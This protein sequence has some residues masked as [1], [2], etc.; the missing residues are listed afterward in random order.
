MFKDKLKELREKE[1]LSQQELADKLFVSRS[2]VAKWENGNGIPSDVNLDAICK[3][4]NVEEEWLLDRKELK[5]IIR[6]NKF[7]KMKLIK[8]LMS[9]LMMMLILIN[10]NKYDYFSTRHPFASV[11]SSFTLLYL[12]YNLF[13]QKGKIFKIINIILVSLCYILNIV[14]WVQTSIEAD[15]HFF[16]IILRR[17]A[18][19]ELDLA[20]AQFSSIINLFILTI[21]LIVNRILRKCFK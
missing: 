5:N 19:I 10:I 16:Y 11:A 18:N 1:G 7:S 8:V 2:A 17:I 4:F 9:L 3:F 20:I 15:M 21:I 14:N 13:N 12:I 6:L